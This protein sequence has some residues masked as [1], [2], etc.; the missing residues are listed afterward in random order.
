MTFEECEL[1]VLRQAVDENE[2][3]RGLKIRN[4][5]EMRKLVQI[6]EEFLEKKKLLCYGGTAINNI[7]P[8][9]VQF[10]DYNTDIPDYDFF[11]DHA[12][13]DAKE[14]ADIYVQHGYTNVEAKSGV[15]HGTYKVF[16]NF[17]PMADVTQI[18]SGLF[19]TLS[20]QAMSIAGIRYVPADFLRMS[21]YLELSRPE[22]N[23]SRW[24]KVLKRLTLLNKYHPIQMPNNTK[25]DQVV[26]QRPAEELNPELTVQVFDI[27]RN[28]FIELEVVFFGGYAHALYSK[29]SKK[30]INSNPD[31]DVLCEDLRRCTTILVERLESVG[32]KST[33]IVEHKAIGELIPESIE[34]KVGKDTVAFLFKPVACHNYN[35]LTMDHKEIRVATIDTILSFYLAFLYIDDPMFTPFRNRHLCLVNF[36]FSLEQKYRLAQ[37][38]LLRRFVPMCYGNQ[39]TMESIRAQK[40]I[41]FA[42]LKTNRNSKEYQEWFLNYRPSE[43]LLTETKNTKASSKKRNK[44]SSSLSLSLSSSQTKKNKKIPTI[45]NNLFQF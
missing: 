28:V 7:L 6:V 11:S 17:I 4:Q 10:Y 24:E 33:S 29:Y 16:V 30:N 3:Q 23:V 36:L 2:K 35:V 31:F 32:I 42:E 43:N 40:A 27:I 12:L 18:H 1:A 38:G 15:H 41:K 9:S 37:K 34:F 39:E 45:F 44:K 8:K 26:I 21:M 22:G 14:L 5:D 20:K 19:Q 25:C 13:E